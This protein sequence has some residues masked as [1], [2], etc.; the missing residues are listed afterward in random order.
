[1]L[2]AMWTL[3]AFGVSAPLLSKV[4]V[5]GATYAVF[6]VHLGHMM[7]ERG[8]AFAK[9]GGPHRRLA[10]PTS[11]TRATPGQ[12]SSGNAGQWGGIW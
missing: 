1:M 2:I 7:A 4:L 11:P 5:L 10:S 3:L 9:L 8:D 12:T 6:L